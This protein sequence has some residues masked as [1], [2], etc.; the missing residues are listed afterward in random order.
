MQ[1]RLQARLQ[2]LEDATRRAMR[3]QALRAALRWPT[4]QAAGEALK[5]WRLAAVSKHFHQ[6][7]SVRLE[8]AYL[9]A[10]TEMSNQMAQ[11]ASRLRE[12]EELAESSQ[13]VLGEE[14]TRARRDREVAAAT[15]AAEARRREHVELELARVQQLYDEERVKREA[16]EAELASLRTLV[17]E[18]QKE[19]NFLSR[20]LRDER[21]CATIRATEARLLESAVIDCVSLSD[22]VADLTGLVTELRF[23]VSYALMKAS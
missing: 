6:V 15:A 23:D 5:H 20:A 19:R 16:M 3:K 21:R 1:A 22:A 17:E 7:V 4:V 18:Q 12:R 13:R 10:E 14:A 9:R 8:T 2:G 11:L